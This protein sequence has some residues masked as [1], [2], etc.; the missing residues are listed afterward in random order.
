MTC[1][2]YSSLA[3][4]LIFG[5]VLGATTADGAKQKHSDSAEISA[6]GPA[7]M[8]S[9]PVDLESRNLFYGP[10]GESHAPH[11]A[12]TFVKEDL[13]GTNPKF[14]VK[15][16]DGVKWKV[17]LG[18]EARPETVASRIVW[19]VG[20]FAD[21]DYFVADLQ[22][23]GMPA[24][25]HRGQKLVDAAGTV[26]NARLERDST[27]SK[28]IGNWRWRRD[29]FDGTREL[30]GLKT[31][32]AVL[33]NWDLKVEN[34][35]IYQIGDHRIYEVSDLGA[36]FGTAGRSWPPEKSKGNLASYTQARFIR[37]I[38][39][40]TVDFQTPARPRWVLAVNPKEYLSRIRLEWIGRNVPRADAKWMGGL[41]SRLSSQQ[42]HDAFHAAGYSPQE[43]DDFSM[44]LA[45]RIA[46]LTDL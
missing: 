2:R 12:V 26:H 31:L 37:R 42:I 28:S 9:D 23:R 35:S 46:Q 44:V 15:D 7:V 38:G 33:N 22:V 43:V 5:I 10:G 29:A 11:G 21:E 6:H 39:A 36:S 18:I 20:Y 13:Q 30:G 45:R 8:W 34:N 4:L 27:G 1:V 19:A 17:K 40:D 32:M 14:T 24:H 25:L 41:L 3:K 16:E